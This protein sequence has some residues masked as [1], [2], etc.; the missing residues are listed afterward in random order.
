MKLD[1]SIFKAYDIRGIYPDQLDEKIMYRIG[2]GYASII[3]PTKPVAVGCDV[4]ISSP[5]LKKSLIK[6]LTDAGVDVVDIGVVSTEMYYFAVGNYGFGGGIQVT[7]SHNPKEWNGAKMVREGVVPISGDA[8]LFDIRDFVAGEETVISPKK[9][10]IENKDILD[11]FCRY[12]LTWIDVNKIKPLK[13]VYN[14]N[15]G[16]EGVVLKRVVEM[17]KLP[18]ELIPLNAEPDGT[19]PKGR[20]DP[21]V[22]ENR[23][24]F[25]ELVKSKNADL[26]IAWDADA[27]RVFFC[28]DGGL[29]LEPYFA[30]TILIKEM[31]TANPGSKVIYDPRCTWA[32]I[33]TIKENGGLPI[34]ERVGHS[35]IK[36]RMRKEDAI[37][38]GEN[39][40]H[41]FY[42]DF[43][44]A[45]SG[46]IPLLQMLKF[47]SLHNQ[48]LSQ[49]IEPLMNKYFL[50]GERNFTVTD[51]KSIMESIK[52]EYSDASL[53]ELD[54]IAC[55]YND[56]RFSLRGSNTEPLL[57]LNVESK[58]K[59]LLAE[60]VIELTKLIEGK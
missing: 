57:R 15:F 60:K 18:L 25:I 17:G 36:A 13:L 59:D 37:F 5:S 16:F 40:G 34:L 44:F 1:K 7:A 41:T 50:S 31:L 49:I 46:M 8:G 27:D 54:G 22:P 6:G 51:P 38:S 32:T 14:P 29:F 12:A 48:K 55:E 4:R 9:G 3:K 24:E 21:Y 58:D 20:P 53:S 39:S 23:G 42:R 19:F 2:Q 33:D 45:D 35:Y 52:I 10:T 30:N 26:G 11:D 56:W 43:W 28:A 47:I